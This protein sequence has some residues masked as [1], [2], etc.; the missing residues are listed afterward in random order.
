MN[1]NLVVGL[2][3]LLALVI[4]I[5]GTYFLKETVPGRKMDS[6][7]AL[8]DQV[9]TLAEGD[10][11]KVNGVKTGRVDRIRLDGNRV[12]VD[13]KVNAGVRIPKDSEVRIQNI[14][15]MGERQ[16]GILLG[17]SDEAF[18]PGATLEGIF[19]AGIAEAMGVAGEV[20]AEAETL[21]RDLRAVVD[22]TV[23][24]P[25]F[26]TSFNRLLNET[27]ALSARLKGFMAEADP[28]LRR[29]LG[30]LD[31]AS[32]EVMLLVREQKE[33]VAEMVA[34]GRDL[35]VKLK[36]VVDKA[37]RLAADMNRITGKLDAGEGTLGA[38]LNDSLF[39]HELKTTLGS[40]DSLFRH[41]R[42]RGLDVNLDLFR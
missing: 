10:P 13:F 40:A 19:D 14:G 32:R 42:A 38:M 34:N 36:E 23:G 3:V 28:R 20:F 17:R 2:F 12:R 25:R 22:S 1:K 31:T 35:S 5:F 7:H 26:A 16:V 8:F 37:D 29:S 9:S 27:E 30:H 18:A 4:L 39:H 24:Q 15:L 33:P 41:I 6:Y 11:V 21:V